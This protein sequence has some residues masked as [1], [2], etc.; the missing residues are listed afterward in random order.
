MQWLDGQLVYSATD[1]VGFLACEHL[2]NL[3]RAAVAGLVERPMRVDAELERIAKRGEQH[4]QRF[5]EGLRQR[6]LHPVEIQPD[7]SI[8]DHGEQLRVAARETIEAMR[9][10]EQVIYQAT[11]FDG[12]RR[13]H[14]DFLMR[15][16]EPSDLGAWGYEVWDT[17]LARHA[18]GSA[19]IQLCLYADMLA[20]LQGRESASM[21]LALGGSAAEM[22]TLRVADYSAYY[23]VVRTA[24]ERFVANQP[25]YP[26]LTRP[27]PVEHC[28]VCK[29]DEACRKQRRELDDL[30][31]VAGITARQRRAFRDRGIPTRGALAATV[32]PLNPPLTGTSHQA[33][34]RVREQARIQVA[35]DAVM[36][37]VLSERL[38]LLRN[39]EGAI[40]GDRG[41]LSLPEPSPGDLFFDIEGDPFALDDGVEYLFGI[42]EPRVRDEHG[43]PTF[44]SFW[45]IED[46]DV[47]PEG[48]RRAFEAFIDLV[49]DRLQRDPDLHVYHYAPYEPTAVR[50]LM[51][52]YGTRE[53]EVD[54]LLRGRVFVDL[55]RAVRQGVRASVESYS[56]KRL[57]PLYGFERTVGLRDAGSSI[58]EFETW[59]ELG[60]GGGHDQ[61]IL[62]RIEAYNRDDCMS[63]WKLRDWLETQRAELAAEANEELPRPPAS[64]GDP[65]RVL[66]AALAAT[67]ALVQ[68][69]VAS[70]P[71]DPQ[72]RTREAHARWLLAQLLNWHR[73]EN[74]AT[75][76]RYYHLLGLTDE[77]LVAEPDAI[78]QLTGGERVGDEKQSYVY[79]FH[80][81]PQEYKLKV[82]DHPHDPTTCA[83]AGE[84]F[85][86]DD[87]AGSIDLK[88]GKRLPPPIP[89]ALVPH[90]MIPDALL[91]ASIARIAQHVVDHGLRA[92]G[93]FAAAQS[94]LLRELPLPIEHSAPSQLH[95]VRDGES[96][97]EAAQRIVQLIDGRYLAIQGPPGSGKT[98]LGGELIAEL[99]RAGK[100]VGVTANSHKVI[101][102]LLKAA[103]E[104]GAARRVPIRVGQYVDGDVTYWL[105]RALKSAEVRATLDARDIDVVGGT[106]WLW[107][108]ENMHQS[109]DVLFVDE[110]GQMSLANV[111]AASSAATNLVLLGDPQQ[112]DQPLQGVHPPGAGRSALAHVLDNAQTMPPERGLFI[113][114]TW[115]LHPDICAYTSELFYDDRLSANPGS[116]LQRVV[117]EGPFAGTG[118]RF[119]PVEHTGRDS[120][121]EEEAVAIQRMV[122]HL[123]A[124]DPRWIDERGDERTLGRD[125][126]VIITP[127]NAQA[128]LIRA[129]LPGVRVGTV[130]KFQGQEAVISIYSMSTS[131]ADDA[132]RGMEFLY[133]L[134][135]L[136]VATSRARCM[137]AIVASP[138]LVL[139]R[140]RTPAQMKLA[141]ALARFI[142]MSPSIE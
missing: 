40:E 125:D 96:P 47:T 42:L 73:R 136:N 98:R 3:D 77:E 39:R 21:Y 99:V 76:W 49:M 67:Q 110:A 116:Q 54:R 126:I 4:E 82:G 100:R 88:R 89:T 46:G 9:R 51:G 52:R 128:R 69:L 140:C 64:I 105:A 102:E 93:S 60:A 113:E 123:L 43:K 117:G 6:G 120:E 48:E 119:L 106:A 68:Q 14:A 115:R 130:D 137:A 17:K 22:V 28:D 74:K 15:V 62:A 131:S 134:N 142:E 97:S 75:W 20:E 129:G 118:L 94:L 56:I 23:R 27:D 58:A 85:A 16:D 55:F 65:P 127:Y 71:E 114:G 59:L 7:G 124:A 33:A 53:D 34:A 112:L 72:A 26:P 84:V 87:E 25:A 103:D 95:L 19:V 36:P 45:A 86:I 133:N 92:R 63:T 35:G 24:F 107:S 57:E 132:P 81:P 29:W 8:T 79:R 111:I 11:F 37:R 104:A 90:D 80:F 41:L 108:R 141:N 122:E 91:R 5:L 10:A 70:V 18:K 139:A 38:P 30:S 13:G 44:H 50:R 12:R 31:L 32:L 2:T 135:R 83:I 78:G 66:S 101:G 109:V 1:L 121:S 138:T 61:T